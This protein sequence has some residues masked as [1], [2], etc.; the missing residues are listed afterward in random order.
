M[1]EKKVTQRTCTGEAAVR[2][3]ATLPPRTRPSG[4]ASE[5]LSPPVRLRWPPFSDRRNDPDRDSISNR[6]CGENNDFIITH[7]SLHFSCMEIG[8]GWIVTSYR[9]LRSL[10]VKQ[11]TN[12]VCH[13]STRG[14]RLPKRHIWYGAICWEDAD[15]AR[16]VL[17]ERHDLCW[18]VLEKAK[19]LSHFRWWN[20]KPLCYK[21]LHHYP[22]IYMQSNSTRKG[23]RPLLIDK[24]PN[25]TE[26]CWYFSGK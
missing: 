23:M 17:R 10:T 16:P 21:H 18:Y 5:T 14:S 4:P 12:L 9:R 1:N 25:Y 7:S 13:C 6:P 2:S 15:R 22:H 26:Q 24:K 20:W 19:R 3:P 8:K 11:T